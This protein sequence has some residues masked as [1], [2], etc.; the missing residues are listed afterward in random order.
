M[1]FKIGDRVKVWSNGKREWVP[2]A[3]VEFVAPERCVVE[4][5]NVED[6]TIKVAFSEGTKW[7]P[8]ALQESTVRL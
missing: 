3:K 8:P 2:N 4:G 1:T 7:I 5:Y 6:G